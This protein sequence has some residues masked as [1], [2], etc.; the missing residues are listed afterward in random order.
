MA[1]SS[2]RP[3]IAPANAVLEALGEPMTVSDALAVR[4]SE[5]GQQEIAVKGFLSPLPTI[6]CAIE[7]APLNPTHLRCSEPMRWVMEQ[8]EQLWGPSASGTHRPTGPAFNPSFALGEAPDV[9]MPVRDD[10][11]PEPVVLVGHFNDRRARLC[12]AGNRDDC[13]A[14]FVVDRVESRSMVCGC[15]PPRTDVPMRRPVD[16]EERRRR[17]R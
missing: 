3:T 10:E 15:Q 12:E 1:I 7:F 14:T 16:D 17:A 6:Y 2:D 8:P 5:I 13:A 4:D 9:P 11:L